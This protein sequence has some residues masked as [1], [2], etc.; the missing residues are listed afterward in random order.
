MNI[1]LLPLYYICEN[2]APLFP[3]IKAFYIS[4]YS[5]KLF[6]FKKRIAVINPPISTKYFNT[7]KVPKGRSNVLSVG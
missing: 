1:I 2:I 3:N 7:S 4:E 6:L 5:L